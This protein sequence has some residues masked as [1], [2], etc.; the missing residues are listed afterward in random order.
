MMDKI[1]FIWQQI[2]EWWLSLENIVI[3]PVPFILACFLLFL[4]FFIYLRK[5]SKKQAQSLLEQIDQR[6]ELEIKNVKCS[7]YIAGFTTNW[8]PIRKCNLYL[9]DDAFILFTKENSPIIFTHNL[10]YEKFRF[11]DIYNRCTITF[12]KYVVIKSKKSSYIKV[13]FKT[14]TDAEKEKLSTFAQRNSFTII[15]H[16]S[17]LK[18]RYLHK[19]SKKK[20]A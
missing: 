13:K 1:N 18:L 9:T 8:I 4:L 7:G 16:N 5:K 19:I 12:G 3:E 6:I 2:N 17:S 15:Y 11:V 14:L 10:G 20:R